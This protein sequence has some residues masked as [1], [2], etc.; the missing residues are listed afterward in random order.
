MQNTI[1]G[2]HI[3]EVI[4]HNYDNSNNRGVRGSFGSG[5]G[6]GGIIVVG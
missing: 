4:G 5:D 6:G 1:I 2:H 3:T